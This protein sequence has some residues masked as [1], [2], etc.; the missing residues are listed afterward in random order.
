MDKSKITLKKYGESMHLLPNGE[1]G[2]KYTVEEAYKMLLAASSTAD[3]QNG[4]KDKRKSQCQMPGKEQGG[5]GE[6]DEG[7][8]SG[9]KGDA[10]NGNGDA[11]PSLE[12][13]I[14]SLKKRNDEIREN[15]EKVF[16]ILT[17]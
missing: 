12:D 10:G 7:E 14:A 15:L 3:K 2:Y 17:K 5:D 4:K 1:E 11:S 9:G 16:N 13:L 8:G 6:A